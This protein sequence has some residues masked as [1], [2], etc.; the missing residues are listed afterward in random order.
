MTESLYFT[1]AGNGNIGDDWIA[2]VARQYLANSTL[3]REKRCFRSG[4][5]G[6][7]C[8]SHSHTK[9]GRQSPLILWGGGWLAADRVESDTI[10]RWK[11][12]VR[13]HEG[14]I[15]TFGLGLGPFQDGGASAVSIFDRLEDPVYVRTLSDMHTTVAKT[16]ISLSC[17]C[18]FLDNELFNPQTGRPPARKTSGV[19][20]P[21]FS[22][23]W[24]KSRPWLTE[25]WYLNSIGELVDE[26]K[27]MGE[28]V[29]IE[30]D[31]HSGTVSDANYWR[32]LGIP[33][34]RPRN[35]LQAKR[36]VS[37]LSQFYTGRLHAGLMGAL[38]SVPTVALAYHH[39]F[40]ALREI[41]VPVLGLQSPPVLADWVPQK[42]DAMKVFEVRTR[43]QLALDGLL[44]AL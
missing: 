10:A 30:F 14:P 19:S 9:A 5:L 36:L 18:V 15:Y 3:V 43:G 42:A 20:F 24:Q 25:E 34:K 16:N 31:H 7:R 38:Q 21:R 4:G 33:S 13:I 1:W 6:Y 11:R 44:R 41:A 29:F 12:H 35:V 37:N 27:M 39:K 22:A 40:E 28:V 23:N 26:L 17:D 32:H 8:L 2:S